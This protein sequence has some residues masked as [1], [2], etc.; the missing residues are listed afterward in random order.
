MNATKNANGRERKTLAS[1]LDR[2]DA[3]LDGLA[4]G[5]TDAVA[6]AVQTAVAVAVQAVLTEVLTNP[7]VLAKLRAAAEAAQPEQADDEAVN[8]GPGR[9]ASWRDW[10][11]NKFKKVGETCRAGWQ[12]VRDAGVAIAQRAARV[13]TRTATAVREEAVRVVATGWLMGH[14]LL[15]LAV[16]FGS[17]VAARLAIFLAGFI[18]S[19]SPSDL[20]AALLATVARTILWLRRLVQ[21]FPW[22]ATRPP[23]FT[24]V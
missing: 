16:A 11:G 14:F 24:A 9:L 8:K 13:I 3:M 2:L 20:W 21:T 10:M 18:A 5:L 6:Q 17:G 19:S 7:D 12:R 23:A 4:D 22:W 1:Q 15:R